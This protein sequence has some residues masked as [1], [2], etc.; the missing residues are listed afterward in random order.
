MFGEVTLR[1]RL[2]TTLAVLGALGAIAAG[3][4]T[5]S[6]RADTIPIPAD[7]FDVVS[8]GASATN[9]DQLTVVVD[10]V[11][12]VASLSAQFLA[13]GT[14]VYGET[15]T[16][17]ST[18]ADPTGP[19]GSTQTTWT[20]TI[21][22]GTYASPGS[23]LPIGDYAV[24]VNGAFTDSATA[25][26][27]LPYAGWIDFFATS[28]VTLTAPSTNLSYPN[29]STA[30]SGQVTLTNPDGTPDTDYSFANDLVEIIGAGHQLSL[31]ISSDGT[32]SDP[33][34][35]ASANESIEAQV[36][37]PVIDTSLS[38][39]VDITVTSVT[40][41]LSL[42]VNPVTETYGKPVTVT[43]KLTYTSA[44]TPVAGQQ[45]WVNTTKDSAGALA[46][47]TTTSTGAFTIT[48]PQQ[49]AGGTLYVGSASATDLS[50]VVEPLTLNVVHPTE[51]TSFATSLNQYWGLSVSGCLGF[52]AGDK[53]ERMEHTSGLTVEY[54]S[55]PGGS[56]KKLGAI[57]GSESDQA[58]G[59]GGIK[60]TGS[61]EAP[62]NYAYYRVVYAGTT[63]ATSYAATNGN[64]VLAWRYADRI[65]DLKVSPTVVN[66]GGKLSVSGTLQYY[67]SGWRNY[68][69]QTIVIY[70]HPKGSSTTWYWLVKVKT[71]SKGQFSMT[72]KD[73]VSATWQAVFDG[74]DSN[75]VG[76]LLAG[77]SDVYVRLK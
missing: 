21:P 6:A 11:S 42:A 17:A 50:G 34:F 12:T 52:P 68:S 43:G 28:A 29:T 2:G 66:A 63:G 62:E 44:S 49:S 18:A 77:S 27:S 47:A 74:N 37:G 46:T 40:P 39:P 9:P 1:A 31:P 59:T 14:G 38:A 30:L 26:Y 4:L 20:A 25:T 16:L 67:Y 72:F 64:A 24:S 69:G 57:S 71:N 8:A 22:V 41:T 56:W 75:G 51:I 36:G 53:T 7:Q 58:C 45:V 55:S 65:I 35:T 70:L 33:D 60:F 10:S 32:F 76:H 73:P 19:A 23:G 3:S 48:L 5:A 54:A 13:N 15:L 61:F